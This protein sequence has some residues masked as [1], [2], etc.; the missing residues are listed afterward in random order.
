MLTGRPAT[1]ARPPETLETFLETSESAWAGAGLL[2][3]SA[4][5]F[6]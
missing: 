4:G 6:G 5:S 3:E 2:S 1:R